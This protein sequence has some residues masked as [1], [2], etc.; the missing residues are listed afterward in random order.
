[1]SKP[2]PL[3]YN[4]FEDILYIIVLLDIENEENI[5]FENIMFEQLR[6]HFKY[7]FPD[8]NFNFKISERKR[9]KIEQLMFGMEVHSLTPTTLTYDLFYQHDLNS[10]C[11]ILPEKQYTAKVKKITPPN[12]TNITRTVFAGI[13][14]VSLLHI[15]IKR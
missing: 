11:N 9:L 5:D 3:T 15:L 2:D 12:Y 14:A 13:L 10:Y 6:H 8:T 1:M 7:C 4:T